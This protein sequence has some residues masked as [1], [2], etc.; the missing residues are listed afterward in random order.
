MKNKKQ[1]RHH[2]RKRKPHKKNVDWHI[3]KPAIVIAGGLA[4]IVGSYFGVDS[5]YN[6]KVEHRVEGYYRMVEHDGYRKNSPNFSSVFQKIQ[7]VRKLDMMEENV[8][9]DLE[10]FAQYV[11]QNLPLIKKITRTNAEDY[12]III[13][14]RDCYEIKSMAQWKFDLVNYLDEILRGDFSHQDEF[15]RYGSF[16]LRGLATNYI[17]FANMEGREKDIL[18]K[19]CA[20][21]KIYKDDQQGELRMLGNADSVGAQTENFF[22]F[23]KN[24][25]ALQSPQELGDSFFNDPTIW[26]RFHTHPKDDPNFPPSE[27]DEANSIVC[28]PNILFSQKD[29][30]LH[31]Y[32]ISKGSS[33]EVYTS[34]LTQQ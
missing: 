13:K 30:R 4:A 9:R 17:A 32:K 8:E 34:A 21:W 6:S 11:K 16:Y 20:I 14:R 18:E 33:N 12:G 2:R 25:L 3:T 26:A 5:Y 31:V 19:A 7:Y 15:I 24:G 22:Q 23:L 28:G 1:S 29:G 27:K 10:S